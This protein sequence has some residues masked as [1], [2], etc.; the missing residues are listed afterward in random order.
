MELKNKELSFR[1]EE[2]KQEASKF[3]LIS[4]LS[5]LINKHSMSTISYVDHAFHRHPHHVS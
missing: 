4:V 2:D 3:I 1:K 5:E